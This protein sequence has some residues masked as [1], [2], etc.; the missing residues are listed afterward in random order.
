MID[1]RRKDDLIPIGR[2]SDHLP[3]ENL[4]PST[5]Y[6]WMQRGRNGVT[7]DYIK[8]GGRRYTTIDALQDFFEAISDRPQPRIESPRERTAR[9]ERAHRE[10][11]RLLYP[12]GKPKRG[13]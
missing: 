12:N 8:I 6:R 10:V 9:A 4:H 7:L 2:V 13:R 5:I 1:I 11:E 3:V